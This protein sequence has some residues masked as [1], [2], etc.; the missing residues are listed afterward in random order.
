[1]SS[2]LNRSYLY[3]LYQIASGSLLRHRLRSSLSV[4][5]IICGVAAVFATL[6]IGEG[7]KREVLAGIRQ[8]GLENIII[9]RVQMTDNS[10][11]ANIGRF[12]EGLQLK[13]VQLLRGASD[14]IVD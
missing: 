4:L 14:A 13:D 9:R 7:A 10:T 12:S 8:L 11:V 2:F 6:S 3:G 5:G 1:M